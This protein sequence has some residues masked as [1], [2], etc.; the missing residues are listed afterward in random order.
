MRFFGRLPVEET[1]DT[2]GVSPETVMRDWQFAK[3]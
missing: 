2:L 1:A 3:K